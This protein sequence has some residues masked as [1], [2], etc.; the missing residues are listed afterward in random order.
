MLTNGKIRINSLNDVVRISYQ[1]KY[2]IWIISLLLVLSTVQP[3]SAQIGQAKIE[4]TQAIVKIT[5]IEDDVSSDNQFVK[6]KEGN[7]F[8]AIQILF[9]NTNGNGNITANPLFFKLKDIEGNEY[10]AELM[11]AKEPALGSSE[12]EAGDI[13]KGWV[14]FQVSSSLDI[15]TL[16]FRYVAFSKKSNWINLSGKAIPLQQEVEK[17]VAKAEETE[18]NAQSVIEGIDAIIKIVNIE[19][20]V[21]SDNEFLRP[22]EENRF[23]AI[24]VL[25]DNTNG[26]D[27][28]A[29][30]PL[31]F[32][33]KDT[34]GNEYNA[35]L[36]SVKEPALDSSE[37]E[38]GD[39]VK[40]WLTFQISEEL[41]IEALKLRYVAFS[42][43]SGWI[44]LSDAE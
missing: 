40:G 1:I 13:L 30:N 25:F 15:E 43:K 29:T 6:P 33:L 7:R 37:V 26:K 41:D 17:P 19:D 16:K 4:K 27:V 20:D 3:I 10:N 12:V 42:K 18:G 31:F 35:E 21:T 24:Q 32:K 5:T 34:E 36:M 8:I 11:S 2:W 28:V 38:E 22:K 9:D 14:T 23:L 44:N 39:I